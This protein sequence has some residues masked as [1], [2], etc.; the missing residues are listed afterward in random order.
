[1]TWVNADG[2]EVLMHGE[3]GETKD[4]GSTTESMRQQYVLEI[5]GT[6]VPATAA[7]PEANDAFIPAGSY[8]TSAY[9]IVDTAFAGAT[10]TV[11]IG[12][13]EADGTAIDAVGIDEDI[14]ITAIDADGDVVV[15]NGSYVGG[16]T[17]VGSADAY[18]EVDYDTAALTAGSGKLIVEYIPK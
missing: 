12:L 3:Q 11:N 4:N 14:A 17:T 2:L 5:T 16:V 1:M 8:I 7:T 18:I 6:S 13:Y 10:A 15:C 9:L